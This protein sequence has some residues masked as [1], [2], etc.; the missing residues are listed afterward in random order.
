[1]ARHEEA[2]CRL[3]ATERLDIASWDALPRYGMDSICSD[4]DVTFD[5]CPIFES[6]C[7]RRRVY[8]RNLA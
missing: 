1:M 6:D 2:E 8:G 7:S 4:Y 5:P 3:S